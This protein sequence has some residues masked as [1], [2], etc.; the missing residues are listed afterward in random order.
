MTRTTRTVDAVLIAIFLAVIALPLVDSWLHIDPTPALDELRTKAPSPSSVSSFGDLEKFPSQFEAYF[1]DHFGFRDLLVRA[2][3]T[4]M[5]FGFGLSPTHRVVVGKNRWLFADDEVLY[6]RSE[7]PFSADDLDQWRRVLE[8]RQDWLADRGCRYL[9]VIAPN[10]STIYPEMLPGTVRRVGPQSRFDQLVAYL[11]ERSRVPVLDL[12]PALVEAKAAA[13]GPIY[14]PTDT[15]WNERGAFAGYRQ[16]AT[17][18]HEWLPSVVPR[19]ESDFRLRSE[20]WSGSDLGR[21]TGA[22]RLLHDE[23]IHYSARRALR[24]LRAKRKDLE[25]PKGILLS[26]EPDRTFATEIEGSDFPRGIIFRDSFADALVPFLQQHFSRL[27]WF[28]AAY[29][30]DP[31]S[32]FEPALVEREHPDVVITEIVERYLYGPPPRMLDLPITPGR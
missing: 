27:A 3:G 6:Y 24:P 15:H 22:E 31:E 29:R 21:M 2:Y 13:D 8:R 19:N 25:L 26:P 30:Y 16:I 11:R 20:P 14:H 9:F 12:R 28:R 10:K 4:A 23:I 1:D 17:A 18:L 7:S 32:P 5:L